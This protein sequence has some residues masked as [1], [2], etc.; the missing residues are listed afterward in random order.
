MMIKIM[1]ALFSV[2]IT[3][4]VISMLLPN[5]SNPEVNINNQLTFFL[6]NGYF[7]IYKN[8]NS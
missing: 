6:L 5:A 4:Y 3:V 7:I 1:M 8:F 2:Y